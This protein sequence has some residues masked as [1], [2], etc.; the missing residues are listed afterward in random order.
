MVTATI[1]HYVPHVYT[2][3]AKVV[4]SLAVEKTGNLPSNLGGKKYAPAPAVAQAVK[5]AFAENHLL[6]T[7]NEDMVAQ[8]SV[9][10]KDRLSIRIVVTGRYTITSLEDFSQIEISGTGDGL[11]TATAVAANIASTNAQ[12]NALLRTL[13]ISEQSVEDASHTEESGSSATERKLE[14]ARQV[15]AKAAAKPKTNDNAAQ[16]KVR[17]WIGT[18]EDRRNQANTAY[19]THKKAGL[20]GADLWAAVAKEVGV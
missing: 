8:E 15:P 19:D 20:A 6:L 10:V 9:V 12:K 7:A 5:E 2:A 14:K 11:A 13:L 18:D 17:E 3:L 16:A 4:N 1:E